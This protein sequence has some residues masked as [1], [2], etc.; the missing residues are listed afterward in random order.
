M[1]QGYEAPHRGEYEAD[2][3]NDPPETYQTPED[4]AIPDFGTAEIDQEPV[5]VFLVNP[6]NPETPRINWAANRSKIGQ[7]AVMIAGSRI[8]R[9]R[10]LI[11]NEGGGA[12]YI[13][14]TAQSVRAD[15]AAGALGFGYK[16]NVAA[17]YVIELTHNAQVWARTAQGDSAVVNVLEEWRVTPEYDG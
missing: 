2:A 14:P 11:Q 7:D 3:R 15:D 6:D 12:I 16:L 4:T 13:G 9:V 1:S 17:N 10:M 5:P 8:E